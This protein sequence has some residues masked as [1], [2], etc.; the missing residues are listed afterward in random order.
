METITQPA[1]MSAWSEQTRRTG[2]SIALVPTMGFFHEGHLSLMRFA[3][4]RADRLVVSLFVN[5]IQ[6]APGEDL[7]RYPRA[8]ERDAALAAANGADILFCPEPAAMY[9]RDFRTT[10]TVAGISE[11]LCGRSRPGHFAGVATVLAKLFNLVQPDRAVFGEKD[12][13]QLAV[14]RTLVRDLNWNI[15]I[16]GHPI[17]REPDGLAMSSRNVYLNK[18]ERQ[19]AL[20]LPLSLE[21]ARHRVGQGERRPEVLRGEINAILA[22]AGLRPEYIEFVDE[23]SLQPVA[24]VGEGTV[25]ALAARSGATRL[26]DNC[27]FKQLD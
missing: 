3:A 27:R 8:R 21:H 24:L 19:A 7:E 13:Q 23:L 20:A 15:E 17:V 5:P 14:I 12:F 22:A 11:G 1:E 6:F 16:L 18:D 2:Q 26:I 9:P 10:V 25:L 4:A